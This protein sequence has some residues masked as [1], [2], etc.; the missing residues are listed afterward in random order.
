VDYSTGDKEALLGLAGTVVR[1]PSPPSLPEPMPSPPAMPVAPLYDV[2][3]R[4]HADHLNRDEQ[5]VLLFDLQQRAAKPELTAGV[6]NLLVAFRGRDF[7]FGDI[8]DRI[9]AEIHR[10]RSTMAAATPVAPPNPHPPAPPLPRPPPPA[11]PPAKTKPRYSVAFMVWIIL[12]GVL[13]GIIPFA[14]G[15]ASVGAPARRSQ[16]IFLIVVGVAW[17]VV[18]GLIGSST[19]NSGSS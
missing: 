6:V 17:F 18:L 15:I 16:A 19:N 7:V 3:R 2:E 5:V 9:D 8:R 13:A 1:L 12:A 10:L 4:I 11:A 14:V